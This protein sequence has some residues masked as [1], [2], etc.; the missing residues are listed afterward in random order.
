MRTLDTV[1]CCLHSRSQPRYPRFQSCP[2]CRMEAP[3]ET[4]IVEAVVNY[5]F[6][7]EFQELFIYTEYGIQM[8]VDNRRA[9]IVLLDKAENFIAIIECKRTGVVT[10][11]PEQLKAYL[12]ATDTQFGIFANSTAPNDWEFYENLRRNQFKEITRD[13]FEARIVAYQPI[14]SIREEKKRLITEVGRACA[15][16][17]QK[18]RELESSYKRLDKVNEKIE[19]ANVELTQLTEK[20]Y[21]SRKE[22]TDLK[23]EIEQNSQHAEILKGLKLKFTH[24]NLKKEINLLGTKRGQLKNEI[25]E[26]EQQRTDLSKE[27]NLLMED[28]DKLEKEKNR[29]RSEQKTLKTEKKTWKDGEKN[30]RITSIT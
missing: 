1:L 20:I 15:Q 22:S 26:K 8:G 9:D 18:T 10:Y 14:E 16:H 12:C 2:M 17:E 25:G 5:F 4:I 11:G 6:K 19:Q 29:I 24:D 13:Q 28:R 27:V 21:L 7:P 30:V 23:E 3:W